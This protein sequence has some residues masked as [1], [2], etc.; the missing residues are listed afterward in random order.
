VARPK[1]LI[2]YSTSSTRP[3]TQ[4]TRARPPSCRV[5]GNEGTWE[6]N[7][8]AW[9][10]ATVPATKEKQDGTITLKAF[11]GSNGTTTT[12][13]T[14]IKPSTTF[15][16]GTNTT[17]ST[18][19]AFNTPS[20]HHLLFIGDSTMARLYNNLPVAE[21]FAQIKK[22]GQCGL[23]KY[24]GFERAKDWIWPNATLGEGP[25]AYGLNNT[26]CTD[27]GGCGSTLQ[28]VLGKDGQEMVKSYEYISVEFARD[29]EQQ[30]ETTKT[31]QETLGLYLN[32]TYVRE[33]CVLGTGLHDVIL[34]VIA[35]QY[36]S[37]V[38]ELLGIVKP[39][40][41]QVV[42]LQTTATRNDPG[43]PQENRKLLQLN[44]A[45][46]GLCPLL[47][48]DFLILDL[49]SMSLP[50]ATHVD[51]VHGTPVFYRELGRMFLEAAGIPVA[52]TEEGDVESG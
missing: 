3:V 42:W 23:M 15:F 50:R 14:T 25:V 47:G 31:S 22:S 27:C 48:P 20:F 10:M 52:V 26:F 2:T 1:T 39:F 29:R 24:Y 40:C 45:I 44:E 49:W 12:T 9:K 8:T 30:T 37:N 11:L 41:R 21:P 16:H 7:F 4:A 28:A 36:A 32:T 19:A 13:T 17:K 43:R 34:N 35:D 6:A 51:N 5:F 33:L 18:T 38:M 46:L